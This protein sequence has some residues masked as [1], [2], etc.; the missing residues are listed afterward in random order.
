MPELPNNVRYMTRYLAWWCDGMMPSM[1]P[2]YIV[3][4]AEL[5]VC[6]TCVSALL[7]PHT[8]LPSLK[9]SNPAALGHDRSMMDAQGGVGDARGERF[10]EM[11]STSRGYTSCLG[12]NTVR[13]QTKCCQLKTVGTVCTV[14]TSSANSTL[15]VTTTTNNNDNDDTNNDNNDDN[16]N[17]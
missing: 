4:P 17:I 14:E 5:C 2:R 1:K 16:D 13:W 6:K 12:V 8:S 9:G 15:W 3:F 10:C 11:P 7:N